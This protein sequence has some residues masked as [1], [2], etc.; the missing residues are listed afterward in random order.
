MSER[1]AGAR[2]FD[3]VFHGGSGSTV[4]EI[5]TAI[6][7]GVVKMNVDTD[8][9]YAFTRAVADHLAGETS[10]RP[11]AQGGV[12]KAV[13]DP[14]GWGRKAEAAMAERVVEAC[15]DLHSAGRSVS[16]G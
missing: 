11:G 14:R 2:G 6:A 8:M 1:F 3:F 12:D 15:N 4:S 10:A 7:N 16:A 13:Y 9:Q 5:Q